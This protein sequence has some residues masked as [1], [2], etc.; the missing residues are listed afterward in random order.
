MTTEPAHPLRRLLDYA[1][2]H[3]GRM[4]LAT[5]WSV[6]NK[7]FDLAPPFLIGAALDVVVAGDSGLLSNWM[8]SLGFPTQREQLIAL[9]V[10]SAIIWAAESAFEYA[11]K[12]GWRTLAQTLQHDLRQDAYASL[13]HLDQAYFED[14]ASG[15]LLTVLNDDV[16]Q[17]ERFLDVGANELLQLA[18][19]VLVIGGGFLVIDP[20]IAWVAFVPIPVILWG[21]FRFQRRL[22]PLYAVVRERAS[23]VSALL[24]NNIGGITIIKAFTGERREEERL[25]SVSDDYRSANDDAIR[26]SS[27]FTPLIR[28]AI[29]VGF[30]ATLALGGLRALDGAITAGT[31]A[32][33]MYLVQRLLWPLTRLGETMDLYQR[34]MASTN[35][36]LD[37]VDARPTIVGGATTL[38]EVAGAIGFSDV[39]FSY[40]DG[41][42][43]LH[44]ID[45]DVPAGSEVAIVGPTGSGK[46][47][48]VKLLLRLYEPDHGSITLDGTPIESMPLSW[49]RSHL[50]LVS[51]DV[52]LFQGTVAENIAYG[53]P[54]ASVDEVEAA[55]RIAEAHDFIVDLPG[56]YATLVGERGQKLS[57]GQRQRISIARAVLADPEV[58]VLDEATSAVDNETEAAIQRSLARITTDRTTIVIAHR[59]STIR[60]ADK[61]YVLDGGRVVEQGTHDDLVARRG[62]YADLWAVQ[63]GEPIGA[64]PT[65]T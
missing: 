40:G 20:T 6:L 57:G 38:D 59:L 63:T 12:V 64:A 16:N 65:A 29:L 34:A 49:L 8:T 56:G 45:L 31:Y 25:A 23:D 19:T 28:I 2:P 21:S 39:R 48:I 44:G 5:V 4:V 50:G 10:L 55:A 11:F 53:R 26:W 62:T 14:R 32:T 41:P 43:V 35:R 47:T 58:L 24:A 7:L 3:R 36:A 42:E 51:Q 15:D 46:S 27:A 54:D 1:S 9:V 13:Q 52:F 17:L 22:E 33:M 37:L 60:N 61:I 18:T 30:L